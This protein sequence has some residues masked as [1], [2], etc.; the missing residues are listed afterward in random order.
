M[1]KNLKK[2]RSAIAE[3]CPSSTYRFR[4]FLCLV[5]A[6]LV[7]SAIVC[8]RASLAA[9]TVELRERVS[10]SGS[11]V[12]LGDVAEIVSADR[13]RV[14]QL[15]ALP[16]MPAPSP[17]TERFLRRRE[18][19]DLL[20]A[21]GQNL[22]GL[23]IEGAEQVAISGPGI[24]SRGASEIRVPAAASTEPMNLHAAI[25]AGQTGRSQ[26][27]QLDEATIRAYQS[28]LQHAIENYL[29]SQTGKAGPWE[30]AV[31]A[32][33]AQLA[34]LRGATSPVECQGGR[35]PWT[36]R[37]RF[38]I[39]FTTAQG[40]VQ[41]PVHAQVSGGPLAV[42]VAVR[43]IARGAMITAADVELQS[44]ADVPAASSRRAPVASVEELLGMEARQAIQA[45]Q[46]IYSD[47]V[48]APILVKR[49]ELIAVVSQGGGIR[50]RTTARARQDGAKGELVQVETE[51]TG[52]RF[53]A[54]V[55]G[56]REATVFVAGN[57][58]QS[59]R[60]QPLEPW[61]TAPRIP[62]P[63]TTAA[64]TTTRFGATRR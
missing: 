11:V 30:V 21:H 53:D 14:R 38:T 64:P 35:E 10:M 58:E 46:V 52:E 18:V 56:P 49:G 57:P 59:N 32:A 55:S 54:R 63:P 8:T 37:Q 50:V 24:E 41:F 25:L 19:E 2:C 5:V 9:E 51:D 31:S 36:G 43:P 42:V 47:H 29:I 3:L 6:Y 13:V 45:G 20:A 39:S 61:A 60:K 34:Q 17:G 12:R 7:A 22:R 26:S 27:H 15:A 33:P 40:I 48:Q 28:Q 44:L 62:L 23:R 4:D 1:H 16:L